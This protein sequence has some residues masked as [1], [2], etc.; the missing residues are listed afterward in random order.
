MG[1]GD[2]FEIP[3]QGTNGGFSIAWKLGVNCET[4]FCNNHIVNLIVSSDPPE[5]PW[6]MSF[7]YGPTT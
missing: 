5:H 6:L 1:F 7:L 3:T 4:G 2:S